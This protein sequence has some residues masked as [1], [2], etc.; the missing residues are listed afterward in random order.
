[1][2]SLG[3]VPAAGMVA[4]LLR[5]LDN[6]PFLAQGWR[7]ALRVSAVLVGIALYARDQSPRN[8]AGPRP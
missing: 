4:L 5:L 2:A 3:L 8:S 6:N 7:F 1:M